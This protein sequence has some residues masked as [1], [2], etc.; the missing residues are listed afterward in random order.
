MADGH[1]RL[2]ILLLVASAL[3]KS[4]LEPAFSSRGPSR[5]PLGLHPVGC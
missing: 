5:R 3:S 4:A 1:H 2:G